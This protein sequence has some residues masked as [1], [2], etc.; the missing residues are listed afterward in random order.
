MIRNKIVKDDIIVRKSILHILNS[1]SGQIGLATNLIDMGPDLFDMIRDN[2]FKVLD[3][4]E[5]ISCKFDI[6]CDSVQI[7]SADLLCA[8]FQVD[9]N[10]Y[11]ALL[12]MNY[13][14]TFVHYQNKDDVTDIVKQN[15][16]QSGKLT[17]AVIFD[18]SGKKDV[19]LVQKK[20]EMLNGEKCNYLSERFL[21]CMAGL[22][23][24]KKFQILNR[25]IMDLINQSRQ[26]GLK[27]QFHTKKAFYDCFVEDGIFD[28]NKIGSEL[29]K[30]N[31]ENLSIY[32][33]KMER[34]DMQF[35]KFAVIKEST[36]S[37][38]NYLEMETDTG[39][40]IKIPMET[41]N[42]ANIEISESQMDGTTSFA[43][44]NIESYKLK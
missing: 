43:I 28:I 30:D 12:K 24:K 37:K 36:V 44:N 13:H 10:I 38:L 8:S 27:A 35:D 2:V 33:Q 11:L 1:G 17:E 6:M 20:Y 21:I 22:P 32:D 26:D 19:Y 5:R 9:G 16:I 3:N 31:G 23:P 39:I 41:F 42:E 18:L 4:D 34:Y 29:F 14:S 15:V 25:T 40:I 7:P